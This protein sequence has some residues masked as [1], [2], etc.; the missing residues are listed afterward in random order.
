MLVSE[1]TLQV[2]KRGEE[3][4]ETLAEKTVLHGFDQNDCYDGL[5]LSRVLFKGVIQL[6]LAAGGDA[7]RNGPVQ[8]SALPTH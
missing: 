8:R 5:V 6:H 2:K 3:R 1:A 4:G 7:R